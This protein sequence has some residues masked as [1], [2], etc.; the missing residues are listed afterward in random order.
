VL[1]LSVAPCFG[2]VPAR[3]VSLT[4]ETN[5][6][7]A[8]FDPRHAL[9]AGLDGHWQGE[10]EKMLSRRS[11]EEMLRAGLGPVSVRL[12]TE[13]A[14]DAWHWNPKGRWSDPRNRQGY[15]ISDARPDAT[16][17][18]LVS[19]GYKLPRRG[20]TLDEANNDG[21]SRIDD[22]DSSTFWKSNPYL[23]HPFT[24][25]ADSRHPQ[26]VVLDFGKSVRINAIRIQWAN[27]YA[28]RFAV[29]YSGGGRVYFGGHPGNILSPVWKRFPHGAISNG[30]G[31]DQRLCLSERPVRTRYLRIWMTGGSDTAENEAK[32]PHDRRDRL[33]YA[34]REISAGIC[35]AGG[36]F[37][38]QVIHRRD[39]TQTLV[40]VSSTDP[41]HRACDRDLKVEQPGI[42]GILRSGIT[43]GLPV[44]LPLPVFYDT[45]EN[46]SA[47]VDYARHSR[48][49][50]GRYELGEEPD[51]QRIAPRDFGAL[52]AQAARLIRK[53]NPAAVLGG[54]SFVTADAVRDD[55]TY[56]FDHRWWLR[57]FRR[58]LARRGQAGDFQFLSFE[59]YPFDDV[60]APEERQIP[61]ASG[62][63]RQA[64][65]RLRPQHLPLVIGEY[66]YSVFPCQQEVDL[67][68]ALLNAETLA[69]FLCLGGDAAY[70]YGY[71]PNHLEKVYGSW[72]NHL[73]LLRGRNGKPCVPVATF[74]ALRLLSQEWVDPKGGRH[75]SCRVRTNLPIRDKNSLS[76]F[77][78]RQPDGSWSLLVINKDPSRPLRLSLKGSAGGFAGPF[79]LS[80]YSSKNYSWHSDGP[81]GH[82]V[83]NRPPSLST[84]PGKAP[85]P[86][87]PW[88]ISVI[89]NGNRGY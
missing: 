38:D 13:L 82:P 76:A 36:K 49:P 67:G 39:K 40:Y 81:N 73:M 87:P 77:A 28:K 24:K 26:W 18:I 62:M 56:R 9:G 84:I 34:I 55:D 10:T 48:Y 42:D 60:L 8:A 19:Y 52:Y 65:E 4:I 50:V 14:I 88:S 58:E 41:W 61:K 66:N 11:V 59:W 53:N 51:G 80:T 72:G 1:L 16:A 46:A 17:P 45:P 7:M 47:L 70:Y 5:Q 27:P 15:W 29:E 74:H 22:G 83:Q 43:R 44:M 75:Q 33:G 6:K 79:Q 2:E 37:H 78:L 32:T 85:I 12:R 54:P 71:E 64:M 68:G 20:N 69:E 23:A 63:L 89:R 30:R 3:D 86:I 25:E 35:E 21:C 31:G 57:A